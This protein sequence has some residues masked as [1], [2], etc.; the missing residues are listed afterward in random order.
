MAVTR[1]KAAEAENPRHPGQTDQNPE[2]SAS[3]L[4]HGEAEKLLARYGFNEIAE[5]KPN[6]ALK[7]LSYF[8]GTIPWLIE[9]AA[10]LT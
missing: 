4:T 9:A 2:F 5:K 8:W 10:L 6:P 7:F 3:G 1:Q